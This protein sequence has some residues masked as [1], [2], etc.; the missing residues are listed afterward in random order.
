MNFE[1]FSFNYWYPLLKKDTIKSNF[2][3]IPEEFKNF[4]LNEEFIID[5]QQFYDFSE[6]IN[7]IIEELGGIVFI[8]L[9][10]S[11][12]TDSNWIGFNR[13]LEIRNFIDIC[14][15][16]KASTR[17]LLDLINPFGENFDIN[18]IL[19]IKK[20][21]NYKQEREFRIFH[22]KNQ[23]YFISSRYL[24]LP[25]PIET[26]IISEKSE[27]LINLIRN[28]LKIDNFILDIYISPKFRPHI[29]DI[30]PWNQILNSYLFNWEELNILEKNE[31]RIN[32]KIDIIP[33]D[34]PPVPI[35]FL[36][37][38]NLDQLIESMNEFDKN[39]E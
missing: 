10:F 16:L 26:E 24:Y 3:N 38:S 32:N 14:Y 28:T 33:L 1:F 39:N 19:T 15:L 34:E 12:P 35:E 21:F 25:C 30:A 36:N 20:W 17:V 8:K 6:K 9:N 13:T 31:I 29:I 5:E 2:I 11:A 37:G 4:L 23:L 27:I 18:P 22:K 7:K